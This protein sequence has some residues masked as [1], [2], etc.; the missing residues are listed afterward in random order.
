MG[1]SPLQVPKMEMESF[2]IFANL[3]YN[4]L[5]HHTWP[6]KPTPPKKNKHCP[7]PFKT[8]I[9]LNITPPPR[10]KVLWIYVGIPDPKNVI[11][12]PGGDDC[13][14]GGGKR[15]KVTKRNKKNTWK[16]T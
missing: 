8:I 15:S 3:L 6:S 14:L 12:H 4:A 16:T 11:R 2:C 5:S 10:N 1:P 7:K 13:I 9:T